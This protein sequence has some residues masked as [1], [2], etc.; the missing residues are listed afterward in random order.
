MRN[1]WHI[2]FNTHDLLFFIVPR[3][4]TLLEEPAKFIQ[5]CLLESRRDQVQVAYLEDLISE[6]EKIVP[7]GHHRL[8]THFALFRE[9]YLL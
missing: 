9:K 3:G 4:N 6:I 2:D 5:S 8:A 1:I 7:G